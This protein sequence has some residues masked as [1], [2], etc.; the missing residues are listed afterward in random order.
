MAMVIPTEGELELLKKMI[1]VALS[2]DENYIL[3]LYNNNVAPSSSSTSSTF[4]ET[5]FTG[6]TAKTLTR[7]SWAT[8]TLVSGQGQTTYAQQSFSCTG[9]GDTIYGYYVLGATSGKVLWAEQ[10][11]SSRTLANG[12]VLNINPQMQLASQN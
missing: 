7:A 12:D 9:T 6:Y 8:P 1:Q 3:H 11:S 4:T 10:F 2:T 5:A